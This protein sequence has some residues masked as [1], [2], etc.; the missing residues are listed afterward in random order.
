MAEYFFDLLRSN[1]CIY[2]TGMNSTEIGEWVDGFK[3]YRYIVEVDFSG[4]DSS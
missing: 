4:F 3:E 2:V 1:G